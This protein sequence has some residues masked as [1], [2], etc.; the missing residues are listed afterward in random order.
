VENDGQPQDA[1][2]EQ[3][4]SHLGRD[5]FL[6]RLGTVYDEADLGSDFASERSIWLRAYDELVPAIENFNYVL[7][8]PFAVGS[9]GVLVR[10]HDRKLG[11]WRAMKVVRPR[12]DR[13]RRLLRLAE[14]ERVRINELRH[15]NLVRLFFAGDIVIQGESEGEAISLPYFVMELVEPPQTL[16]EFCVQAPDLRSFKRVVR[17]LAEAIRYLHESNVAHLDLKPANVLVLEGHPILV[18]LGYAKV[19]NPSRR[20]VTGLM[21]TKDFAHPDL[22]A[23]AKDSSDRNAVVIVVAYDQIRPAFDMYSLGRTLFALADSP[24]LLDL[25]SKNDFDFRYLRLMAARMVDGLN[26]ADELVE[27]LSQEVFGEIRYASMDEAAA[28]V[29]RWAGRTFAAS[30]IPELARNP[31][32]MIALPPTDRVPFSRRVRE[33]VDHPLVRRLRGVTQLGLLNLIYPGAVHSRL[34]HVLGTFG[35]TCRFLVALS[36]DETSPLFRSVMR[37]HHLRTVMVAALLHDLGQ[38]PLAHDLEDAGVEFSHVSLTRRILEDESN[39]IPGSLGEVLRTHWNVDIADV[40]RILGYR[41]DE[42][43]GQFRDGIL[44][45]VIDGPIDADKLD[46]LRRD[47][48][49]LG[50]EYGTSLDLDRLLACLTVAFGRAGETFSSAIGIVEKGRASAEGVAMARYQMF[51]SVYWHHASRAVKVMIQFAGGRV[52][53]A[54]GQSTFERRLRE[55]VVSRPESTVDVEAGSARIQGLG[56]QIGAG[57]RAMLVWLAQQRKSD[58]LL[59]EVIACLLARDLYKRLAPLA[60]SGHGEVGAEPFPPEWASILQDRWVGAGVGEREERRLRLQT[61]LTKLLARM[62]PDQHTGFMA[63]PETQREVSIL[64]DV[65]WRKSDEVELP[66]IME[67]TTDFSSLHSSPVWK[68]LADDLNRSASIPRVFVHPKAEPYFK[69]VS[70]RELAAAAM[71][72]FGLNEPRRPKI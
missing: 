9:T 27:G 16:L 17:E 39:D 28:D 67:G 25:R 50:L 53:Q 11:S 61:E 62:A 37:P 2:E 54:P 24:G 71:K 10:V 57:D 66:V 70:K 13:L 30:T 40:I 3:P 7:G 23:L 41:R 21:V 33:I 20:D 69:A 51:S 59:Q 1:A 31:A 52:L 42:T 55:V 6:K 14:R 46:Y 44:A 26:Q 72:V 35:V 68:T 29:N 64:F 56:D 5:D 36:E 38:Y 19:M 60:A 58:A 18:D 22:L 8:E 65:P 48:A 63:L 47:S 4:L 12:L 34:E 32:D 15:V 43:E 49:H 45:R